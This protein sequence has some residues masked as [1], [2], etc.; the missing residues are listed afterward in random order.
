MKIFSLARE[1]EKFE[2]DAIPELKMNDEEKFQQAMEVLPK[3]GANY[4][5]VISKPENL[6]KILKKVIPVLLSLNLEF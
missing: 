2:V 5:L 3:T 6:A 4:V 1:R